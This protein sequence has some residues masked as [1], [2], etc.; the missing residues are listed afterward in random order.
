MRRVGNPSQQGSGAFKQGRKVLNLE[1]K[2]N[3]RG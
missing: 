1:D 3:S 2:Y